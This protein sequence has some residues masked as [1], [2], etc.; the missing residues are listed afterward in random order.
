M[1]IIQTGSRIQYV[2]FIFALILSCSSYLTSAFSANTGL[3]KQQVISILN[4]VPVYAVTQSNKEGMILLDEEGTKNQIAYFFFNP[5]TANAVFGPLR[6]KEGVD[7]AAWD[8]TQFQLGLVWFELVKG[9]ATKNIDYRFVPD[10]K[11]LQ[12][13][14][15]ILDPK[16]VDPSLFSASYDKVPIFVDQSLR[17]TGRDGQKKFPMYFSLQDLLESC[18]QA[19]KEYKPEVNVADF[20][21]LVEQ[22]Q[23]D[24]AENDFKNVA[25]VPPTI[26]LVKGDDSI[27][28]AN[29]PADDGILETPTAEDNWD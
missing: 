8:V 22:M 15:K 27:I 23:A 19:N 9:D 3:S 14:R 28:E 18:Q 11:E 1:P 21:T 4:D 17:V 6:Q 24:D 16:G 10:Y 25:L 29:F 2:Y 13:A 5:E 20:C 12:A 26:M 7:A